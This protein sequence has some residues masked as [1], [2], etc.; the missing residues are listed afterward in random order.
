MCSLYHLELALTL[1]A[2]SLDDRVRD[3]RHSLCPVLPDM[4]DERLDIVV[5]AHCPAEELR[6]V[7]R[8]DELPERLARASDGER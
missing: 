6:E 7:A 2:H 5:R 1:A 8:A 3:V 4:D